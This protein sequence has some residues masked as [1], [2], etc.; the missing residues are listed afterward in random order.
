MILRNNPK[1]NQWDLVTI[2]S[3]EILNILHDKSLS[4][5]NSSEDRKGL[6]CLNLD[7]SAMSAL[8]NKTHFSLSN[9]DTNTHRGGKKVAIILIKKA[10]HWEDTV[11]LVCKF[12]CSTGT[13]LPPRRKYAK[14]E[15]QNVHMHWTNISHRKFWNRKILSLLKVWK[16]PE[17]KKEK[18][19]RRKIYSLITLYVTAK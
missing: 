3:E 12:L 15:C 2:V 6:C 17:G 16:M 1:T 5:K 4:E 9:S 7:L 8:Q 11:D 19:R 10:K 13:R 18:K 14:R